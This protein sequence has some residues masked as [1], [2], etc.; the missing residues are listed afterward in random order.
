MG[1]VTSKDGGHVYKLTE[2]QKKDTMKSFPTLH[3]NLE[4]NMVQKLVLQPMFF[5]WGIYL[6]S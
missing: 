3:L 4:L 6:D 2:K 1:K 5:V